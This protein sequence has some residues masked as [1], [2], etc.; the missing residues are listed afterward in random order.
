MRV[1]YGVSVLGLL[2]VVELFAASRVLAYNEVAP[3]DTFN[4]QRFTISQLRAYA[5]EQ[6]PPGRVLSIS[7]A[8]FDPGDIEALT[9]RYRALGMSD[10]AIRIALVDTKLRDLLAANLPLAWGVPS[11]DGFDGGLLPSGD[12]SAF[13]S[14][15]LP[16][17]EER[18]TDGR[19]REMLAQPECGGACIPEQR[20]LNL[21]N[22]RYLIVDKVY[23]LWQDDVAYDTTFTARL[24]VGV[25]MT[26]DPIPVFEADSLHILCEESCSPLVTFRY[27]DGSIEDLEPASDSIVQGYR[28]VRYTVESARA[29]VQL[30]VT[31]DGRAVNLRAVTLVDSRTGDF[32]QVTL[33]AWKRGL[34]SDIKLYENQTVLPRAFVVYHVQ[35]ETDTETALNIMRDPAF[36]PSIEAVIAPS[37]NIYIGGPS[38]NPY[39]YAAYSSVTVRAYT[40]ERVEIQVNGLAEA[41]LLLTDAY[42]P[43]WVATVNGEPATIYQ[44]DVMFRAVQVPTGNST[45][46]F[47]YQPW[48]WPG[49]VVIGAVAWL[50]AVVGLRT[51]D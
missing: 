47:S 14:L 35:T 38:I 21:T 43:G 24:E 18:S 45:V 30:Q 31:A 26:L 48:W 44:A 25:S 39:I 28:M 37:S 13:T 15:M 41:F 46:V 27:E 4:A 8:L 36:D 49:I 12:Y 40:P 32:Q 22:T 9:R 20:W 50:A 1:R 10:L 42:Y 16:P 2:A 51:K 5:A 6:T 3:P 19:L 34:S 7:Q 17:G 33:G 23:D 29:A 11:V